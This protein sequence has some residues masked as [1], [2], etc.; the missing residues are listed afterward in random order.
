MASAELDKRLKKIVERSQWE[1]PSH[2]KD[3]TQFILALATSSMVEGM[4]PLEI[5]EKAEVLGSC[6]HNV[7]YLGCTYNDEVMSQL[8]TVNPE[9]KL[10]VESRK[11]A[12]PDADSKGGKK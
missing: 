2:N 4:S 11:V 12:E 5:S 3:R 8:Y 6:F 1:A 9:L 7:K 10:L